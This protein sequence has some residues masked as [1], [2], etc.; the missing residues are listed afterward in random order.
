MQSFPGG[1]TIS[2]GMNFYSA[3][4]DQLSK[5]NLRQQ[6]LQFPNMIKRL[7]ACTARQSV[8]QFPIHCAFQVPQI[9]FLA[10]FFL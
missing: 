8:I 1:I 5:L 10:L 7:S 3:V 4:S 9:F 2:H 6:L